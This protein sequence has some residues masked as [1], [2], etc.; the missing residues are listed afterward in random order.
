MNA[1]DGIK[2]G[3]GDK[4][5][6]PPGCVHCLAAY[7]PRDHSTKQCDNRTQHKAGVR[8]PTYLNKRQIKE[9][10]GTLSRDYLFRYV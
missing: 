4:P 7:L 6:C 3:P 10:E 1:S 5:G 9:C 2:C 8:A